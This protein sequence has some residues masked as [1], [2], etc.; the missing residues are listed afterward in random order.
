MSRYVALVDGQAGA[1]GVVVP[2]LLGCSS[3]GGEV[4][5]ALL[6][7]REAISLWAEEMIVQGGEIPAPHGLETL[8][9]DPEITAMIGAGAALALIPLVRNEG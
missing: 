6:N 8:M 7:A 9:K 2:D 4:D 1:Y 3:G 5:E